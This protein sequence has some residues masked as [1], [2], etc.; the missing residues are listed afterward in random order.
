MN[1]PTFKG[2]PVRGDLPKVYP[3]LKLQAKTSLAEAK[4]AA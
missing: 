2:S 1:P 4:K 3:E